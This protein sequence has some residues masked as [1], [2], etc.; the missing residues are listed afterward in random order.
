MAAEAEAPR[1]LEASFFAQ[2][3]RCVP[4]CV[5]DAL[6][7]TVAVVPRALSCAARRVAVAPLPDVPLPRLTHATVLACQAL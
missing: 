3:E 5:L 4:R 2:L 1:G 6:T 7:A